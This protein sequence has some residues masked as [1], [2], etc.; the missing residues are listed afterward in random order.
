MKLGQG[1]L[2]IKGRNK[3]AISSDL[4]NLLKYIEDSSEAC[5]ERLNNPVV[6]AVHS[7]VAEIKRSRA[8]EGRYMRFEELL[9]R[10]ARE[11]SEKVTNQLLEL[12]NLI[13]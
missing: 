3:E 2:N 4:L 6:T 8:W 9:Q 7:R 1:F 11:A 5:A 13:Q 12:M 10:S